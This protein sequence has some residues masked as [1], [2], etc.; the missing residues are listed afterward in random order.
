MP[1]TRRWRLPNRDGM[2]STA[3]L[4]RR[5]TVDGASQAR[6][7]AG[8]V[9][10]VMFIL[11]ATLGGLLNVGRY[12]FFYLADS[13]LHG[14][15]W[16]DVIPAP[17][18]YD[19]VMYGGHVYVPF[20]PFPVV[21]T[22]PLVAAFGMPSAAALEPVLNAA[23]AASCALAGWALLGRL[24]VANIRDRFALVVL[25]MFGTVMWNV[26]VRGGVWHTSEVLGALIMLL[27]LCE[28]ATAS[29]RPWLLGLLV[30]AAALSRAP[31][32]FA[33]PY[34][35]WLL[36][37][38]GPE[39]A[40]GQTT[41]DRVTR[42]VGFLLPVALFGAID[43]VYNWARFGSVFESGYALASL[44]PELE[45]LREMGLFSLV[46]LPMNLQYLFLNGPG[47]WVGLP[48]L[49]RP[50][51]YGMSVLITSPALL[52]GLWAI[53]TSTAAR[54]LAAAGLAVLLPT[55]LYYGG[56]W[57]QLGYRYL[58]DSIPFW[59]ALCGLVAARRGVG[60]VWMLV[61]GW[62]V[63]VNLWLVVWAASFR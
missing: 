19:W 5:W 20:Q 47:T 62:S 56:G 22:L 6:L 57:I 38:T 2:T 7:L 3:K 39:S 1:G 18:T 36:W 46:H 9:A 61:I 14:H 55:L 44:P 16:L 42:V 15:L 53:R 51:P 25:L 43:L 50:D 17:G 54:G 40:A 58:L 59:F 10:A 26:T 41:R 28:G 49:F 21:L 12:D 45:R 34:F 35:I 32:L 30:G 4:T 23:L 11:D 13:I 37:R 27:A 60:R 29:P 33:A 52:V 48:L 63:M 24:G 31:M 8:Y